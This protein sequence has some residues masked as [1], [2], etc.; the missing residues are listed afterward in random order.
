VAYAAAATFQ[1]ARVIPERAVAL[2]VVAVV[3]LVLTSGKC[4]ALAHA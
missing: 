4:G 3:P 2:L 1:A